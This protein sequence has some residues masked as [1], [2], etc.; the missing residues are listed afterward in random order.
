MSPTEKENALLRPHLF[1]VFNSEIIQI[2]FKPV[3]RGQ[4]GTHQIAAL[5]TPF[6]KAATI[7]RFE[8]F[9]K[10]T[11]FFTAV[12]AEFTAVVGRRTA[13]I[14]FECIVEALGI[15]ES[16]GIGNFICAVSAQA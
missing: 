11:L 10:A 5:I 13:G 7:E 1:F 3:L 4:A 2:L 6:G 14:L 9:T 12:L 15:V 8:L 16:D